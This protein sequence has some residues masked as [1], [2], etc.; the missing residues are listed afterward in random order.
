MSPVRPASL[1]IATLVLFA[2]GSTSTVA[3]KTP[4]QSASTN[5]ASGSSPT[6][7]PIQTP[8]APTSPT[9]TFHQLLFA[10]LEAKGT[11]DPIAWNTVAIAGLD[12]YARAKTTFK[13]LATPYVGCAGGVRPTQAYVAAGKVFFSD[14]DGYI[15][16]LSVGGQV[17]QVTRF[18]ITSTQQFLSFAVSPDGTRLLGSVFTLPPKPASGDPCSGAATWGPGDFTFDVF[19]A[20]AGQPATLLYHLDIPQSTSATM[21]NELAFAGWTAAGPFGTSPTVYATQGG[22]PV[23]YWGVPVA[24]DATT[25]KVIGPISNQQQCAVWDIAASGDFACAPSAPGIAVSVRRPNDTEIWKFN[26]PNGPDYLDYLSPDETR[27][28]GQGAQAE[29]L[30]KSGARVVPWQGFYVGWLNNQTLI[31]TQTNQ[32]FAYIDLSSPGA[33]LDIGFKGSFVGTVQP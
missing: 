23:H 14:G 26:S 17:V 11:S 30:S 19:S 32:N 27:V 24:I 20:H 12:G 1:L 25:G 2:C 4:S 15:R 33:A 22:G 8:S 29:V 3:H 28:L 7:P 10:A 16:S 9:A 18:A 13:P 6:A 5:T 31:G 21:P